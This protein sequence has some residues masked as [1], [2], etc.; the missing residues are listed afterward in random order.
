MD[1]LVADHTAA[2]PREGSGEDARRPPVEQLAETLR[3]APKPLQGGPLALA[4]FMRANNML[5]RHYAPLLARYLLLKLRYGK[6]LQTD[7]I[8]FVCPGVQLE[9]GR[10]A[11][12][13]IGRWAWLGH[14]TKIRVHEGEVCIG[15]KTVMGQECTISAFQHVSIGRECIVADRVMLIDFDHGAVEVERPVRLQGIYKRDVR[16][17]HNVWMGYGAC[18]LRGVSIGDNSIVGT[19]AVITKDIPANAV[20]AGSPARVIRMREAPRSMRWE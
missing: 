19:S 10:D 12:L 8:C 9:I 11:T 6:R 1:P 13:R 17:G 3:R 16:V 18:V 15:A 5:N 2:Q 4:R 7:G 20:V 14:G